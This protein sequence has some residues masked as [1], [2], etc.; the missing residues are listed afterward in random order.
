MSSTSSEVMAILLHMDGF[1]Y[2][3]IV[4][5][6]ADEGDVESPWLRDDLDSYEDCPLTELASSSLTVKAWFKWE[7][8]FLVGFFLQ[9]FMFGFRY[10]LCSHNGRRITCISSLIL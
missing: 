9:L 3:F 2:I 10:L 7:I 6:I 8:V 5:M 4:L 1:Q